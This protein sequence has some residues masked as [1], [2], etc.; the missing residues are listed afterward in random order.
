MAKHRQLE[1]QG[2]SQPYAKHLKAGSISAS[3][4]ALARSAITLRPSYQG[5]GHLGAFWWI[6]RGIT[7][8]FT[9]LKADLRPT[10]GFM[11]SPASYR[12]ADS[13]L[14]AEALTHW[15]AQTYLD[16]D[17][18]MPVE[19]HPHLLSFGPAGSTPPKAMPKGYQPPRKNSG[20]KSAPDFIGLGAKTHILE[21]KGRANFGMYGVT[22]SVKKAARNKALHQVCRVNTVNGTLPAT[23]TACVFSFEHTALSAWVDHPPPTERLALRMET[24]ELLR[25]YYAVILDPTFEAS[26]SDRGDIGVDFAPGWRLSV[27]RQVMEA[28]QGLKGA[29][30]AD[31]LL[32]LLRRRRSEFVDSGQQQEN[33]SIGPDGLRLDAPPGFELPFL[34]KKRGG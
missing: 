4:L 7:T 24:A 28:V 9:T 16:V 12:S 10:S 3:R 15:T 21:S 18:L 29:D 32:Q 22:D 26:A 25:A 13:F 1:S 11:R 30:S 14:L 33:S 27:D 19:R 6:M 34:R 2:F 5:E 20:I 31:R 17:V 23:R 8:V